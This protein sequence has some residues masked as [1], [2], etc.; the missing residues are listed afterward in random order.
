MFKFIDN[1]KMRTKIILD[2]FII[3]LIIISVYT[4]VVQNVSHDIISESSEKSLNLINNNVYDLIDTSVKSSVTSYLKGIT[5][6]NFDIVSYYYQKYQSGEMSERQA[7]NIIRDVLLS[8]KIGD[9]GYIFVL[10]IAKAPDEIVVDIH[11]QIEGA[12]V[13][14]HDFVRN[15]AELKNGYIEYDW[16]N[17]GEE[18]PRSK[19]MYINYFEEWDWIIAVSS[20]KS[21][22]LNLVDMDYLE[23]KVNAVKLG[24][25]DYVFVIDYAGNVLIHPTL[26]GENIRDLKDNNDKYFMREII[27]K[28]TGRIEYNWK[29]SSEDTAF[30]KKVAYFKNYDL[31]EYIIVTGLYEDEIYAQQKSFTLLLILTSIFFILI[32]LP[33]LFFV[34]K[35]LIKDLVVMSNSFKELSA[36]GGDLTLRIE[37]TSADEIGQLGANFNKFLDTLTAIIG[38][39]KESIDNSKKSSEELLD[40]ME[41][42]DASVDQI[43]EITNLVKDNINNQSNIVTEVSSAIEEISKTI[44]NQD[45]RISSQTDNLS[46]SSAAIEEM[47]A[48]IQSI[49]SN[50]SN[51]SKEFDNLQSVVSSGSG[52]LSNLKKTILELYNQSD[53]VIEANKI[54]KNIA[55]QTNLLAMNAAIE[56]AHAGESGKGFAVV[57]DEIRNLAEI[58]NQQS[59]LISDNLSNLKKSIESS[60]SITDT[61]GESFNSIEQ[62][63]NIVTQLEKEIS[64]SLEEQ[65]SG[66]N[67]ILSVLND[68]SQITDEVHAGSN[69]MIGSSKIMI[70]EIMKLVE[71]TN[72]VKSS[73]FD[74]NTRTEEVS[75]AVNM[76]VELLNLNNDNNIKLEEQVDKFKV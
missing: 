59:K 10:N 31:L 14:K 51:S 16:Q 57:A 4:V 66:S 21:E 15:A 68:I 27:D 22:F 38:S 2:F 36:G 20:Y 24:E 9:T 56:A 43:T 17:P 41:N 3:I 25:S 23:G 42:V 48:N 18:A 67:Q 62:S 58:S 11:P 32:I 7:R 52:N 6:K 49:S 28:K 61:T 50:L 75:T 39:V 63:V 37:N 73:V 44:E 70:K 35:S 26:K 12:E 69:Q 47:I 46:N 71:I 72:Q 40:A 53:I 54:I 74:V 1:M 76:S 8:Q 5:E 19:A 45:N 65:T 60:V 13:S 33:V 29:K 30:Y 55:S 34:S 64:K